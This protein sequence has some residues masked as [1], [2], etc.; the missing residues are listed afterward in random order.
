[1]TQPGDFTLIEQ[2]TPGNQQGLV[3]WEQDGVLYVDGFR[4]GVGWEQRWV[5][6][7]PDLGVTFETLRDEW[8]ED[9]TGQWTR[10]IHEIKIVG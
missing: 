7:P 9:A 5:C 1:M 2:I 3:S 4:S 8:T 6:E 10:T